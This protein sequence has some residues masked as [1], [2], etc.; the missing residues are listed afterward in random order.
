MGETIAFTNWDGIVAPLYDA[1]CKLLVIY[2]DG[3]RV[4]KDIEHLSLAEKA[5]ACRREGVDVIICGAISNTAG[6]LLRDKGIT[7]LSWICGP[8]DE[9]ID[10]YR[11]GVDLK[12]AYAMPGCGRA[13]CKGRR[14]R[15]SGCRRVRG[16]P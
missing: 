4:V 2:P 16:A 5:D 1:C 6:A 3:R 9:L 13:D 12:R 14:R 11:K 7:P 15:G 10:A 8:I